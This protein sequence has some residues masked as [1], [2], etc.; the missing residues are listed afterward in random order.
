MFAVKLLGQFDVRHGEIPIAIP[1]RAAQSLLAYLLL[2]AGTFHRRERLA[3]LLWPDTPEDSAR[4]NLRHE[5][6]RLR[7][8]IETGSP[9]DREDGLL[10]SDEL[11]I[12]FNVHASYW[13]DVAVLERARASAASA[14]DL[15]TA[16]A[17]YRGEL[18]PGFYD[19][20]VVLERE[21]V[22]A[23]F[24]Q[25]MARLLECLV[26]EE[27]WEELAEWGER[28]I[29]LGGTPEPA[30]R[31]LMIAYSEMGDR[32]KVA[33]S[34]QRCV[35]S[36]HKEL[37]VLPTEATRLLFEQLKAGKGPTKGN[38]A[39]LF[40]VARA[41]LTQERDR[42]APSP[43]ARRAAVQGP[44][45]L[46]R[47]RCGPVL[48]PR[49]PHRPVAYA[50]ASRPPGRRRRRVG[51][52]QIIPR[53]SGRRP[54]AEAGRPRGPMLCHHADYA[55]IDGARGRAHPRDRLS[56]RHRIPARRPRP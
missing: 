53:S 7:K 2:T 35:E 56:C 40:P 10:L 46:R 54:R 37:G 34:Y 47:D 33:S 43:Y 23:I 14:E 20:W 12:G 13:L 28:W 17:L 8:A 16:L 38:L 22:A 52:R 30:Y 27:R 29:A 50:P 24:E 6:W 44:G 19:E 32:S 18:L 49:D 25:E 41:G 21:R 55:S 48:W 26:Q 5:L 1:F 11:S 45:V 9:G 15:M 3:G 36:L 42:S 31:G 51:Q 39:L 4:H